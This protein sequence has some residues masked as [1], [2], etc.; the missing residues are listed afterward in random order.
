MINF[1][2]VAFIPARSGSKG[3]KNKN[4]LPLNGKPLFQHSVDFAISCPQIDEIH[5]SSDSRE[6]LD[7]VL[8][9]G[10]VKHLRKLDLATDESRMFDVLKDFAISLA[11]PTKKDEAIVLLLQPTSPVRRVEEVAEILNLFK[12]NKDLKAVYSMI[13]IDSKYLKIWAGTKENLQP[14]LSDDTPFSNRQGL[15]KAFICDGRFYAIKLSELISG[16]NFPTSGI[17][18]II[19]D[20]Q[21]AVDIDTWQDLK[22]LN[23]N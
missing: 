11:T 15:P 2:V 1:H 16:E 17:S 20:P 22:N 7:L 14:V 10:I 13:E 12:L 19:S 9:D 6:Y 3:I 21:D 18:T 4:I 23:V 8:G 5:F